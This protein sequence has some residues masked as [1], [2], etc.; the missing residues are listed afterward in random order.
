MKS[1]FRGA[2]W[3]GLAFAAGNTSLMAQLKDN[4]EKQLSCQ[5]SGGDGQQQRHCEVREQTVSAMGPLT[6]DAGQNGGV[7]VKGWLRGDVLVRSRVEAWGESAAAAASPA[8]P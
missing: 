3:I 1:V 5:N 4:S 7:S 6:V 2:L 8:A